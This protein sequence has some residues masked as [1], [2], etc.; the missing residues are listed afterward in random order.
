MDQWLKGGSSKTKLIIAAK[1]LWQVDL[2]LQHCHPMPV[3]SDFTLKQEFTEVL[4]AEFWFS[5]LQEYPAVSQSALVILLL[6]PTTYLCDTGF[7]MFAA[8]KTNIRID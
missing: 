1:Q 7:S 5:L 2:R 6:C 4:L 8:T 3:T